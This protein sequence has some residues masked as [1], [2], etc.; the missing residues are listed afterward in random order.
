LNPV[1]DL[2]QNMPMTRAL[3]I[4]YICGSVF[5]IWVAISTWRQKR[6]R[7]E[8]E[9]RST[10]NRQETEVRK[11]QREEGRER[12]T[13][14]QEWEKEFKILDATEFFNPRLGV[15][16]G[17]LYLER[18]NYRA[19][20]VQG[21]DQV[22]LITR[23]L[24]V[25]DAEGRPV[26]VSILTE[27]MATSQYRDCIISDETGRIIGGW[28]LAHEDIPYEFMA[29]SINIGYF[30]QNR[31][32]LPTTVPVGYCP[33]PPPGGWLVLVKYKFTVGGIEREIAENYL[34]ETFTKLFPNGTAGWET[35]FR[36]SASRIHVCPPAQTPVKM[37]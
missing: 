21:V 14:V 37:A 2:E 36:K 15:R 16:L 28:Q 12:R 26:K 18:H 4:L 22:G 33:N 25:K 5:V 7:R 8:I 11:A 29:A 31:L 3:Q 23:N 17:N 10:R 27:N 30:Y 32:E 35:S 6:R 34:E 19:E 24:V 13:T 1:V 9:Q 20:I